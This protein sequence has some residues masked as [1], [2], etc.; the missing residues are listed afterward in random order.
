[1]NA[2]T[3]KLL[4]RVANHIAQKH[5]RSRGKIPEDQARIVVARVRKE[6]KTTW[7]ETP[8]KERAALRKRLERQLES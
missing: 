4:N 2:K 1:M 3:A 6:L 8:K 7:K 5:I